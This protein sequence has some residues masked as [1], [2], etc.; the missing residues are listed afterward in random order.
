MNI[1]FSWFVIGIVTY[2]G[3]LLALL[4]L[5][6]SRGS[7]TDR[8]DFFLG[9]RGKRGIHP[10][11]L[12][13]SY[14][15]TVY[16]A[17]TAVGMPGFVYTHGLGAYGAIVLA[18]VLQ[19][20]CILFFGLPLW[21]KATTATGT[22]SPIE[23]VARSYRSS[24]LGVLIVGATV[25]FVIPHVTTQLVGMGRLIEG[26]TGGEVGYAAG[27][28]SLLVVMLV[29]S[30]LGGLRGIVWTD[31]VQFL[32]CAGGMAA[33]AIL[34]LNRDWGGSITNLFRDV[35]SSDN[36]PLLTLPGPQGF[37]TLPMLASYCLLFGLWPIGH[38]TYS[39]RY[40]AQST[41]RGF[42]WLVTG[43]S[44][45]PL[46]MFLP[47][48]ILGLGGAMKTPGL[49]KGDQVVG[50]VLPLVLQ[51]GGAVATVFGF[52]FV[53]GALSAAMSTCD[54]QILATG[55][56]VSRDV[57]RGVLPDISARGEMRSARIVMFVVLVIAYTI[58][59]A[60]PP[61]I[62]KLSIL[63]GVGT[64]I[65]VPTYLGI[66]LEKPSLHAALASIACGYAVMIFSETVLRPAYFFGFHNGL[67][68]IAVSA[69]VYGTVSVLRKERGQ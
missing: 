55:Q 14:A 18:Q 24:A 68:A 39:V 54:S 25:L 62:W 20:S 69:A 23:V 56:I 53:L 41:R 33:L 30:E 44:V 32:L 65:L 46:V 43:M 48:L 12:L 40:L 10:L 49:E 52:L 5:S 3:I 61:L 66:L 21:K 58:G 7:L 38:P 51:A 60:D 9:R 34:F 26:A 4:W 59:M 19:A 17:F 47:A 8:E 42:L 6:K 2:L 31:V 29:Y 15:A 67:S 28:G 13:V 50:A 63:S 64:A 35:R 37:F 16:S 1:P 45:L 22:I 57:V 36:A 11:L 27:G